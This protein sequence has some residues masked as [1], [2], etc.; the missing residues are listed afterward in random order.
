M[1]K[2]NPLEK[3]WLISWGFWFNPDTPGRRNLGCPC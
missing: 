1:V 2:G 3:P